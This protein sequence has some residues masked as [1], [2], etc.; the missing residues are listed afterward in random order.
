MLQCLLHK[1]LPYAM[2][3]IGVRR[4]ESCGAHIC[5]DLPAMI[6]GMHDHVEQNVLLLAGERFAPGM[7]RFRKV[8]ESCDNA[9]HQM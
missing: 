8:G 4:S 5:G 7:S 9:S 2:N 1:P 6:G 3:K